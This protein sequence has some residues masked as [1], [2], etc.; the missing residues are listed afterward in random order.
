M[1]PAYAAAPGPASLDHNDLHAEN[2]L[3]GSPGGTARFYDWG[4]AV[5]AHPFASMLVALGFMQH[6]VLDCAIDDPRLLRLR[7]AYLEPF[8][9]LAPRAELVETLELA[10]RVGM[11]ARSL[12][13]H[14]ALTADPAEEI[15][16]RFSAA[17]FATLAAILHEEYLSAR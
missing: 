4:D 8:T 3:V 2:V 13:W 7:D 15:D 16:E 10:C 6:Q 14:R 5:V 9:G 17:P 1:R 12:I 11:T